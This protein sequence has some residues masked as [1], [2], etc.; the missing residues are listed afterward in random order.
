M[1]D[2]RPGRS[3]EA[4]PPLRDARSKILTTEE[5]IVRIAEWRGRGETIAFTN[6][7]FDLLHRGHLKSLEHAA[8]FADRLIVGVNSDRSARLLGKGE[9]RPINN[10]QDRALLLAGFQAVDA[11]VLFDEPTPYE[12]LSLIR[13]DVLA[14]GADYQP[15]QVV[16]REFAKRVE[17][18]PLVEGISTTEMIRR[19]RALPGE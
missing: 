10:Q 8:A 1:K 6:G 2:H 13:P 17:R 7:V 11:V 5:L 16:G 19:I 12:L 9:G 14:K 3:E 4:V 18:I 15:D